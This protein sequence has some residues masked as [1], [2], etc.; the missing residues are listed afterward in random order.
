MEISQIPTQSHSTQ[1]KLY[2]I[3][4]IQLHELRYLLR[5]N[6][7][8]IKSAITMKELLQKQ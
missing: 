1:S 4:L 2:W 7:S 8:K 3:L 6:S 5:E